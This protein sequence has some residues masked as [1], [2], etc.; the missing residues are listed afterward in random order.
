MVNPNIYIFSSC[1][2]IAA[3]T[4]GFEMVLYNI[5]KKYTDQLQRFDAKPGNISSELNQHDREYDPIMKPENSE[6][7]NGTEN[8]LYS[9]GVYYSNWSPYSPRLFFPH[10]IDTSRVSH[11]YYSFLL[12][13][14]DEGTIKS[15][16]TWSDFQ[17]DMYKPLYLSLGQVDNDFDSVPISMKKELL[18]MGCIGE[19]FYLRNTRIPIHG[20]KS[21]DFK[22]FMSVGGWSNREAFPKMVRDPQKV[23]KFINSCID[24]M[25]MYGFDG[26]D[27]DWEFPEDDGFEPMMYLDIIKRLKMKMLE[28]EATIY[29]DAISHNTSYPHFE[30]SIAAPAF[31]EKL[32]ILPVQQMDKFVDKWNMMTYD[33][34]GEWSDVTGYHSNLFSPP[35]VSGSVMKRSQSNSNETLCGDNAVKYMKDNLK[36]SSRKIILGMAA[37]GRGFSGVSKSKTNG[38]LT[39]KKFNGVSGSS[40]DEPGVWLYNKLP[41]KGSKEEFDKESVSAYCY[42]PKSKI[43][44]AYDNSQSMVIKSKY[45]RDNNLGGGFLWEACGEKLN[46]PKLSLINSF[47]FDMNNI[48]KQKSMFSNRKVLEYYLM[49]YGK[50]GFL[51]GYILSVLNRMNET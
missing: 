24:T 37:Y 50:Q 12:V 39:G 6:Q 20:P 40:P 32:R 47:T 23:D 25:F 11:V 16:D 28:L 4:F 14:G 34:S 19:F 21:T 45:V 29:K 17:I 8:S 7:N 43:F 13:D 9:M 10:D 42:D 46:N 1:I 26:I 27:L 41:I 15:S 22:V 49:K 31:D 3:V 36:I 2:F 5:Y 51:S 48:D 44:V 35:D 30:L 18:P 38:K 33:Y